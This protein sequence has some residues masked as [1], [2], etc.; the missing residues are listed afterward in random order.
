MRINLMG[1]VLMSKGVNMILSV[2]KDGVGGGG[3]TVGSGW[4]SI[5]IGS[6]F[7]PAW[8]DIFDLCEL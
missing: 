1:V 8:L 7:D 5:M 2:G 3:S 4:S 6:A